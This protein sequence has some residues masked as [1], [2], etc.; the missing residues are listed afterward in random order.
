MILKKHSPSLLVADSLGSVWKKSESDV[1]KIV[2]KKRKPTETCSSESPENIVSGK[3]LRIMRSQ[4]LSFGFWRL[5]A[6]S[7]AV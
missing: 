6:Q 7:F 5:F 1:L 4:V 3:L 2:A